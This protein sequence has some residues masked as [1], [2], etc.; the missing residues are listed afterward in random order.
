MTAESIWFCGASAPASSATAWRYN[1]S[2][3]FCSSFAFSISFCYSFPPASSSLVS[4]S[5]AILIDLYLVNTTELS[6]F[7]SS[8]ST[9]NACSLNPF[10]SAW[11]CAAGSSSFSSSATACGYKIESL[12]LIWRSSCCCYSSGWASW[13]AGCYSCSWTGWACSG[14]FAA[15]VDACLTGFSWGYLSQSSLLNEAF[16]FLS[17]PAT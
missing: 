15:R 5:A 7:S 8:G 11:S 3:F 1:S 4:A 17:I 10:T 16:G 12:F 6:F 13:A 2:A 9:S 14:F